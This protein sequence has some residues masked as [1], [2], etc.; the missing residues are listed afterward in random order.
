MLLFQRIFAVYYTMLIKIRRS[1]FLRHLN[2]GSGEDFSAVGFTVLSQFY[3]V[4]FIIWKVMNI[5]GHPMNSFDKKAS[6]I[7]KILV[8]AVCG[9]LLY[10]N[11]NYFLK[12]RERRNYFIDSF[13]ALSFNKKVLW[14][15]IAI[16]LMISPFLFAIYLTIEKR[17]EGS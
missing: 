6:N 8:V 2:R 16:F 15:L 4:L 10:V 11:S 12:N 5:I 13:R 1:R 9:V 17:L 7:L 14:N 3:I